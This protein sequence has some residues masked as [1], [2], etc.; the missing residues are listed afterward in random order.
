MTPCALSPNASPIVPRLPLQV[1]TFAAH[2]RYPS[3]L[4]HAVL[5]PLTPPG[6]A[7]LA[8]A[9]LPASPAALALL[10]GAVPPPTTTAASASQAA[11]LT[12]G[13]LDDGLPCQD[14]L[15]QSPGL[16]LAPFSL[17]PAAAAAAAVQRPGGGGAAA[18]G[19]EGGISGAEGVACQGMV[20]AA[21]GDAPAVLRR[22]PRVEVLLAARGRGAPATASEAR[23]WAAEEG[24]EA[25]GR[26]GLAGA[27]VQ[28]CVLRCGAVAA[29]AA[30][31]AVM[32]PDLVDLAA[33]GQ[34]PARLLGCCVAAVARVGH[35]VALLDR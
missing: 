30:A 28:A 34:A 9:G 13:T 22:A 18:W 6:Q 12:E 11:G 8:A 25:E 29:Q 17:H 7:L 14:F 32:E 5:G 35:R 33:L 10:S 16:S 24:E 1:E 21:P 31:V 27:D 3:L 26:V 15:S 4:A 2:L 19:S 23:A 20:V